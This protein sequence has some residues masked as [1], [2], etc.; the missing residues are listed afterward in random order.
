MRAAHLG[1]KII[2][3]NSRLSSPGVAYR[4]PVQDQIRGHDF[5]KVIIQ[6]V[7]VIALSDVVQTNV[8]AALPD[9]DA[10]DDTHVCVQPEI[11]CQ[12]SSSNP[13]LLT[14]MQSSTIPPFDFRPTNEWHLYDPYRHPAYT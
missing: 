7:W 13:P 5:A 2:P 10:S 12:R 3:S 1:A 8:P 6:L 11:F 4:A 9:A 14:D